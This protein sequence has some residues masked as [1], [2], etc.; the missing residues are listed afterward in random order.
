MAKNGRPGDG[1]RNGAVD[2][3]AQLQHP[4]GHWIKRNTG[5]G[6]IMDVKN[7]VKLFKGVRKEKLFPAG[8][9]KSSRLE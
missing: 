1:Q 9:S 7:D 6:R 8:K 5:N 2:N 3:R 4:T